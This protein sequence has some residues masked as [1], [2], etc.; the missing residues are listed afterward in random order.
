[1]SFAICGGKTK[2]HFMGGT[3]RRHCR[4]DQEF[5]PRHVH[6]CL[7]VRHSQFGVPCRCDGREAVLPLQTPTELKSGNK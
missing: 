7:N 4:I 2:S 5:Y 6:T 3:S 1:M